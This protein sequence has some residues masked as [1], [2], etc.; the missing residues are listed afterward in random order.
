MHNEIMLIE[1]DTVI[2]PGHVTSKFAYFSITAFA[3]TFACI[4]FS[5]LFLC[6]ACRSSCKRRKPKYIQANS[7]VRLGFTTP[8]LG[9]GLWGVAIDLW[10]H[11]HVFFFIGIGVGFGVSMFIVIYLMQTNEKAI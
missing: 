9:F 3:F 11:T 2:V 8:I 10:L 1:S 4:I 5:I 7:T 6:C